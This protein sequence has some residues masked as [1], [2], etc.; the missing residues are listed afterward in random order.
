MATLDREQDDQILF[1][2]SHPKYSPARILSK[3]I[4]LQLFWGKQ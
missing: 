2:K 3:L 4:G 1:E